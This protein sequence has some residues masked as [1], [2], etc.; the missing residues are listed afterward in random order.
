[1]AEIDVRVKCGEEEFAVL[2]RSCVVTGAIDTMLFCDAGF[3][4]SYCKARWLIPVN[5]WEAY[6]I[7]PQAGSALKYNEE[8]V[9]Y[10]GWK[11]AKDETEWLHIHLEKPVVEF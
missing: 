10:C 6:L 1:M 8:P 3:A 2:V 5:D 9:R 11:C 7:Q 4:Q